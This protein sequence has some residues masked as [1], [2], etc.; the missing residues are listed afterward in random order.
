MKPC[1]PNPT[2]QLGQMTSTLRFKQLKNR[3]YRDYRDYI[4]VI[5]GLYWDNGKENGNYY[6]G[7]GAKK[8]NIINLIEN[9][10]LPEK[11]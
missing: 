5:M 10:N 6:L 2:K 1:E 7:P 8:H 9:S 4:G 11:L 3:S